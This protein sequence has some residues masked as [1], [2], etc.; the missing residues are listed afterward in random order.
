MGAN[1]LTETLLDELDM[2]A[3]DLE[4]VTA[5]RDRYRTALEEIAHRTVQRDLSQLA[6]KALGGG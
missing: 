5:E 6:K 4:K 3:R 1:I 2:V